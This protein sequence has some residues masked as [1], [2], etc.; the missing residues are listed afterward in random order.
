MRGRRELGDIEEA[1][2]LYDAQTLPFLGIALRM[3]LATL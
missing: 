2:C 3:I 1:R